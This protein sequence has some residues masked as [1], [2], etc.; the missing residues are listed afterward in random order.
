MVGEWLANVLE[1]MLRVSTHQFHQIESEHARTKSRTNLRNIG[2]TQPTR[3]LSER[4]Y[5]LGLYGL[6]HFERAKLAVGN[7]RGHL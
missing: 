7:R 3:R 2:T 5:P 4:V 1:S 6:S